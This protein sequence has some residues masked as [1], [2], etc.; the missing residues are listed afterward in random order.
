MSLLVAPSVNKLLTHIHSLLSSLL[1][2]RSRWAV[3]LPGGCL[4]DWLAGQAPAPRSGAS[5]AAA[6]PLGSAPL[7]L[8]A[9]ARPSGKTPATQA[10]PQGESQPAS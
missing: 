5:P 10:P 8:G 6:L 4:P 9:T 1:A 2:S 7:G 3:L